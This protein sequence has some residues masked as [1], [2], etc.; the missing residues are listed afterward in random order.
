MNYHRLYEKIIYNISKEI[1]KALNE[2]IQNFDV[3]DY[4]DDTD[5]I[6][7]NQTTSDI[8]REICPK[9]N[10]EFYELVVER[11]AK[12]P[13]NP[14]LLDIDTV[15]VTDMTNLFYAGDKHNNPMAYYYGKYSVTPLSIKKLD[16][17]NWN[18]SNVTTMRGM[19]KDCRGLTELD[20][21]GFD[22]S[23]V[24]SMTFMFSECRNL[25]ELDLSGF[26]T[27]NVKVMCEMF[28]GC[29]NL[30]KLDVS[31]FNT[32]NVET[33]EKMFQD[34]RELTELDVSG[35]DTTNVE[36][37]NRMFSGCKKLQKLDVSNFV[38]SK[39]DSTSWMRAF[40]DMFANCESLTELDISKF[41]IPADFYDIETISGMFYNCK[42][43][44]Q[45]ILPNKFLKQ[46]LNLLFG[47]PINTKIQKRK[48]KI[49]NYQN[50][51]V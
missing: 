34:C 35:F 16:L 3:S 47:L 24:T 31:G 27:I 23:N 36:T 19:F 5:N 20:I 11:I 28:L 2:D 9:T 17:S 30:T 45:I 21:S 13:E 22:T 14:Y 50:E 4:E 41:S 1:K 32:T 38:T 6:I 40:R 44:K 8:S 15:N 43:L 7:D 25:T 46:A 29:S 37:M 12:N 42:S 33:M 18:T 10:E 26:N 51:D 48:K 39:F 49:S